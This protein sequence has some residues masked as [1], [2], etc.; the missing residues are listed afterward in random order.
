[1]SESEEGEEVGTTSRDAAMLRALNQLYKERKSDRRNVCN[2]SG[3]SVSNIAG[4]KEG[5]I[6]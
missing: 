3:I 5:L 6:W 1:M 4:Y 2:G